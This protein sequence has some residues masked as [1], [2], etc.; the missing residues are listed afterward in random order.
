[1][2]SSLIRPVCCL[3]RRAACSTASDPSQVKRTLFIPSGA[4]SQMRRAASSRVLFAC[5]GL[6]VQ[7]RSAWALMPAT[8]FGCWWPMFV[9]TSWDEK[10][11]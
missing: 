6:I 2:D 10:S 4:S 8:T 5:R 3:A 7:S 9:F 1:M 11:R